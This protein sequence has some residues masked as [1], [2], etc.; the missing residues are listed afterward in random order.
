MN[1]D[2]AKLLSAATQPPLQPGQIPM[3]LPQLIALLLS[4]GVSPDMIA[5]ML[6]GQTK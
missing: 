2:L 3:Q 5:Q 6:Q 1:I 4:K